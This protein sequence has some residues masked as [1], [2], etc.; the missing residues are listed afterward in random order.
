MDLLITYVVMVTCDHERR[1][2]DGAA[3]AVQGDRVV[4]VGASEALERDH[5]DLAPPCGGLKWYE[6]RWA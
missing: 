3:V 6:A 4:A 5:P 2:M 1:V